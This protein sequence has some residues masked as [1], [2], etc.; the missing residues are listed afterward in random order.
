M[1]FISIVQN[2]QWNNSAFIFYCWPFQYVPPSCW[3]CTK[4]TMA[5]WATTLSIL[6]ITCKGNITYHSCLD[7]YLIP[8]S[9]SR[10]LQLHWSNTLKSLKAS[11]EKSSNISGRKQEKQHHLDLYSTW[12]VISSQVDNPLPRMRL[13]PTMLHLKYVLPNCN[14]DIIILIVQIGVY[15][16]QWHWSCS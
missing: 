8:K 16:D 12:H 10:S 4:P 3:L 6:D 15:Y 7:P 5:K 13:N 11:Y 2:D 14:M 9:W 1:L